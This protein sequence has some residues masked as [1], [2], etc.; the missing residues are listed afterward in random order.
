MQLNEILPPNAPTSAFDAAAAILKLVADP[1]AAQSRL[2]AL[3][4]ATENA[5]AMITSVKTTI[6]EA[7]KK[8]AAGIA[9]LAAA[10]DAHAARTDQ[11][12][13]EQQKRFAERSKDL[14][15]RERQIAERE[16]ATEKTA[17]D[18]AALKSKYERRIR[19]MESE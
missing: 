15:A 3:R 11:I 13:T 6:E 1:E 8:K 14:D 10:K 19:A 5:H 17:S 7:E 2:D 4:A 16:A 12:E 9:E 18:L